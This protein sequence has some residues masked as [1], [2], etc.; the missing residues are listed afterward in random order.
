MLV[1]KIYSYIGKVQINIKLINKMGIS[2]LQKKLRFL[3][4]LFTSRHTTLFI[5]KYELLTCPMIIELLS[6]LIKIEMASL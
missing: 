5:Y 2:L 3:L 1:A 6:K 4:S